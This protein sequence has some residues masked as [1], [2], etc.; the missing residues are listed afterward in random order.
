MTSWICPKLKTA[1]SPLR[2]ESFNLANLATDAVE[3]VYPQVE[4]KRLEMNVRIIRMQNEAVIGDPFG[5]GRFISI[6]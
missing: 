6:F 2:E 1:S 3:L 4:E 5:S